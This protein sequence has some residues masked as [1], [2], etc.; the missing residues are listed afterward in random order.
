[1]AGKKKF[2]VQFEDRQKKEMSCVLLSYICSKDEVC[3]DMDGPISYLSE[4]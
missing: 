4:K 3:L 1:M 2:V